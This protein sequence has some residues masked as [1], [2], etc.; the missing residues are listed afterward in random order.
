MAQSNTLGECSSNTI[1]RTLCFYSPP[2]NYVIPEYIAETTTKPGK[3]NYAHHTVLVPITDIRGQEKNFTLG[4][5]SFAALTGV[6]APDIEF[7]SSEQ[8][9][10][11]YLPWIQNF[12]LK[13]VPKATSVT[14]FDFAVRR[15]SIAKTPTRQVHKIHIDQ[16]PKGA[17]LRARHHLPQADFEAI[18]QGHSHFK[19]INVWKP[20]NHPVVDNPLT[21]AEYKSLQPEDLVP[22]RQIYPDY[23]GETYVLKHNNGQKFRYWSDMTPNEALL[24]QCF[25]SQGSRKGPE[26]LLLDYVQCAHGSFRLKEDGDET[27]TR[28]SIEV[29]CLVL[30]DEKDGSR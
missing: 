17:Y 23:V 29:R 8:V 28:E 14:V 5:H 1:H 25:D 22:V 9:T 10:E 26:D 21:F 6:K 16:S 7:S 30:V 27:Y 15:A 12:I 11:L 24:L 4:E 20:I 3:R 2:E 18:E 13:E 19:I